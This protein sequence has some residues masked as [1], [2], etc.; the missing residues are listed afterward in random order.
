[1]L[2]TSF[3]NSSE[4]IARDTCAIIATVPRFGNTLYSS[5]NTAPTHRF[6]EGRVLCRTL[7]SPAMANNAT[8]ADFLRSCR[9]TH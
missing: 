3:Y 4:Q 7:S 1:M 8:Q 9:L 6:E 5:I 2:G